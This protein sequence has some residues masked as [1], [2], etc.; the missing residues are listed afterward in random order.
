MSDR[1]ALQ[2]LLAAAVETGEVIR[3]VYRGGTRPGAVRDVVPLAVT[4]E[5]LRARD[6]AAGMDKTFLLAK[7]ALS[8]APVT[9]AGS[10]QTVEEAIASRLA[11][12]QA[13]GWH[14]ESA[15]D[16]V[17]LHEFFKNGK[18]RKGWSVSLWFDEFTGIIVV[19]EDGEDA[20]GNPIAREE[21][22]KSRAPYHVSSLSLPTRSFANLWKATAFFL[23]KARRGPGGRSR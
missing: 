14:V 10:P 23:E 13:L 11:E 17:T 19:G 8:A 9:P 7:L 3:I 4:A 5:E 12:M 6:V 18:P 15:R 2:Q 20:D 1:L 21:Q 16:R 22:W